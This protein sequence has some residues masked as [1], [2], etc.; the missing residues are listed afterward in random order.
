MTKKNETANTAA[1]I[2]RTIAPGLLAGRAGMTRPLASVRAGTA[3]IDELG[4]FSAATNAQALATS[5]RIEIA[6]SHPI[7]IDLALSG[8]GTPR[9]ELPDLLRMT[10]D[11]VGNSGK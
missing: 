1:D 8:I 11:S 9:N 3:A 4:S 2:M 7:R 6:R 5:V 10:H